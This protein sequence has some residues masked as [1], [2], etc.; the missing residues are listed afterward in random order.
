[1][2]KWRL[3]PATD[4]GSSSTDSVL[5]GLHLDTLIFP[6]ALLALITVGAFIN[7]TFRTPDNIRNVL[8]FA[9]VGLIVALGETLVILARGIDLSVGSMMA[10]SGAI[11]AELY[12]RGFSVGVD[13]VLTLAV[14]AV[15]GLVAH[16]V[17]ITRLKV[18]VLIVT[19]GTFA[20]YRSLANVILGGQSVS[21]ESGT[22]DWLAN[23]RIGPMPVLVLQSAAIYPS[24]CSPY[25]AQLPTAG[26]FMRSARTPKQQG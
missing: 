1:M 19:L 14:C 15:L 18:S 20:I 17:V 13:L 7:P 8:T 11:F 26:P 23:G 22:L 9:A 21:V 24:Y 6:G 25:S 5:A 10:L 12:T 3:S 4:S 16:G 2:L